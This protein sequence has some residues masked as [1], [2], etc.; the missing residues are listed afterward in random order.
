MKKISIAL[1]LMISASHASAAV[2]RTLKN[3]EEPQNPPVSVVVPVVLPAVSAAPAVLEQTP[4]P[5]TFVEPSAEVT[6]KVTRSKF[7]PP[8]SAVIP[9]T[10]VPEQHFVFFDPEYLKDIV[11]CEEDPKEND[12]NVS[13]VPVP[14]A[15]PLM[16]T[17]LGLFG[18]T[19]RRKTH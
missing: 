1:I 5:V 9:S 15:L 11:N 17:A 10:V 7:N 19:R 2:I 16:A 18:I 4:A 13:A 14:A 8:Q 3:K 12:G 6:K